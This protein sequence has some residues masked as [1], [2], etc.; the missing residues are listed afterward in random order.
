MLP[1]DH[2]LKN[3]STNCTS[4]QSDF[5]QFTLSDLLFWVS[6][7]GLMGFSPQA[8]TVLKV[9]FISNLSKLASK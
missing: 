3:S 2:F 6:T 8:L 9:P 5:F 4:I 7:V 1:N